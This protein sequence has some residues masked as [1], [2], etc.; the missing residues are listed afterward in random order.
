MLRS[1]MKIIEEN[2][3]NI[4]INVFNKINDLSVNHESMVKR[5]KKQLK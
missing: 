2:N 1:K 5:K 4:T 3:I